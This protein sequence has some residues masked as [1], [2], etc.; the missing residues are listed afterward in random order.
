[1]LFIVVVLEHVLLEGASS[2]EESAQT[3]PYINK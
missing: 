1:M 3:T 2:R